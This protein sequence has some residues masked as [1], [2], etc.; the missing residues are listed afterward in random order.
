MTS[1][2]TFA[3]NGFINKNIDYPYFA[4]ADRVKLIYENY[5]KIKQG[6]G[7]KQVINILDEPDETNSTYEPKIW[8]PKQIGYTYWYLIQRKVKTGSVIEK[9]EIL[10]R[11][12]FD[13]KWMV[14]GIDHWGFE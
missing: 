3:N 14:T 13:L 4:T 10:V 2:Y 1:N 5:N 11:V 8:A 6:M 7:A 12:A 9:D